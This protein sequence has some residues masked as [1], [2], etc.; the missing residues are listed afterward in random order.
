V[1]EDRDLQ[2]PAVS[3]MMV[4]KA[5]LLTTKLSTGLVTIT[6]STT[7]TS[8]F[9][10]VAVEALGA[11]TLK[12]CNMAD[13]SKSIKDLLVVEVSE[14]NNLIE[15][16]DQSK[17][18]GFTTRSSVVMRSPMEQDAVASQTITAPMSIARQPSPELRWA[19]VS[20]KTTCTKEAS[21]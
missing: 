16:N 6:T 17:R 11:L 14:M 4:V 8:K 10:I 3:T 1:G 2:P 13:R 9:E 12:T 21:L 19:E 5:A 15:I 18:P 7:R 20:A